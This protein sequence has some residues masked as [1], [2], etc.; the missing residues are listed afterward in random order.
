MTSAFEPVDSGKQTLLPPSRFLILL[1]QPPLNMDALL[2]GLELEAISLPADS[3][4]VTRQA[5]GCR[6][7]KGSNYLS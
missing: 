6:E 1:I 5:G 7:H 3:K 4:K 2:V